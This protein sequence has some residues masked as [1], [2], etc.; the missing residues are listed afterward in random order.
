MTPSF[1]LVTL[2]INLALVLVCFF[3]DL[4]LL[5]LMI[6]EF[7]GNLTIHRVGGGVGIATAAAAFYA[8]AAQLLTKDIFWFTLPVGSIPR[9]RLD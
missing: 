4:T 1:S 5:L 2:R 7:L 8:G 3:L 9:R 6:G